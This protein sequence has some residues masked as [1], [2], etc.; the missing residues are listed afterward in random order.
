MTTIAKTTRLPASL[1]RGVKYRTRKEGVDE[2]TSLRQL[3]ILGLQE[4]AVQLYREGKIGLSEA[5]ELSNQTMR[6]ML[7]ILEIHGVRGNVQYETQKKSLEIV[8]RLTS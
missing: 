4:Y 8:K 1:L 2:S 7:D 3:L 6:E 5:A